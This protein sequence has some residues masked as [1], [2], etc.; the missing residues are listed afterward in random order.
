MVGLLTIICWCSKTIADMVI[1]EDLWHIP[2]PTV[3]RQGINHAEYGVDAYKHALNTYDRNGNPVPSNQIE[4]PVITSP[5]TGDSATNRVVV[6][7]YKKSVESWSGRIMAAAD[8][9]DLRGTFKL[10]FRAVRGP[11]MVADIKI[12]RFYMMDSNN[13]MITTTEPINLGSAWRDFEIIIDSGRDLSKVEN[14]FGF[15]IDNDQDPANGDV[16]EFLIDEIRYEGGAS[17]PPIIPIDVHYNI[18]GVISDLHANP[19][20]DVLV[21]I[22]ESGI[23]T[24]TDVNGQ[25]AFSNLLGPCTIIPTKTGYAFSQ[26]SLT[27]TSNIQNTNFNGSQLFING[28]IKDQNNVALSSATVRLIDSNTTAIKDTCVADDNGFYQFLISDTGNYTVAP[29]QSKYYFTPSNRTYTPLSI[30]QNNQIFTGSL[31][32]LSGYIRNAEGQ[33]VNDVPILLSYADGGILTSKSTDRYGHFEFTGIAPGTY[34]I[35]PIQEEDSSYYDI[36]PEDRTISL[37]D[38]Q[39]NLDFVAL[40]LPLIKIIGG[41]K[42]YINPGKNEKARIYVTTDDE[43]DSTLYISI[44]DLIGTLVWETNIDVNNEYSKIIEWNGRNIDNE[45]VASGIYIVHIRGKYLD[46]KEKIAIIK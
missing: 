18:T 7:R 35:I 22:L 29:Y 11:T 39:D 38:K 40:R 41:A 21:S 6:Y 43:L 17:D 36:K 37:T 25:Y 12:Q 13:N 16:I 2:S 1:F 44:Y 42:G 9:V 28:Y 45:L 8:G 3:I 14:V 15:I 23:S 24:T 27:I 5:I 19:I 30:Y 20:P 26:K 46:K 34:K 4:D 31:Y 33:G 10:K 32:S